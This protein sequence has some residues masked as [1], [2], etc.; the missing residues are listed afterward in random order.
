MYISMLRSRFGHFYRRETGLFCAALVFFLGALMSSCT[1]PQ[2]TVTPLFRGLYSPKAVQLT[3]G[4]RSAGTKVD[5][6][7]D[8][9]NM[10]IYNRVPLPYGTKLDSAYLTM[11]LSNQVP[12][13][14]MNAATGTQKWHPGDTAKISVKGGLL[15]LNISRDGHPALTYDFRIQSYGYDPN[16]LTWK[17]LGADVLPVAAERGRVVSLD[18][19]YYFV[20]RTGTEVSLYGLAAEPLSFSAQEGAALPP[21]SK[22]ET[23]LSDKHGLTW[24]ATDDGKLYFTKDLRTWS[25]YYAPT[26]GDGE[27]VV[28]VLSD[29][30]KGR[31]AVARLSV[32]TRTQAG[33]FFK[34]M[35]S[36]ASG[37]FSAF[38]GGVPVDPHFPVKGGYIYTYTVSGTQHSYLFG[39]VTAMDL[40]SEKAY[41]TS[42]GINWAPT[43]FVSAANSVP[44]VGGLYLADPDTPG[45]LMLVGGTYAGKVS[46]KIKVSND[47]GITWTELTKEQLPP[48]AFLPRSMSS[49]FL[50][51]D[52][53]GIQHVYILGGVVDGKPSR[54][55]WHGYLDTSGGVVNA[56][57]N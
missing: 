28:S 23:L 49:G 1:Q 29:N 45:R 14:L 3:L 50:M 36:D 11:Y 25:L 27:R 32:I 20:G 9:I 35:R 38:D 24:M 57:E 54:E 53:K 8:N 40:P 21:L 51:H 41:F 42:D 5:F 44:E 12:M 6:T 34:S 19:K 10:R 52:A 2:S 22:P 48:A 37:A 30:S 56:F 7:I 31:D 17:N 15:K 33:Y 13:S 39:G 18:G 16:K 55:V 46:S 47:R 26:T 43:P 4:T